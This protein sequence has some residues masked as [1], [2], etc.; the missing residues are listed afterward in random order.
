MTRVAPLP[1]FDLG[2]SL[3]SS[4]SRSCARLY[5]QHFVVQRAGGDIILSTAEIC[6][7]A[8]PSR[9][10]RSRKP[11]R[12]LSRG[13]FAGIIKVNVYLF[14]GEWKYDSW[15]HAASQK[16]LMRPSISGQLLLAFSCGDI[17][18][19][20]VAA[21]AVERMR[22]LQMKSSWLRRAVAFI[23]RHAA[24]QQHPRAGSRRVARARISV[25]ISSSRFLLTV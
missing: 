14:P 6:A 23:K 18:S 25:G 2:I 1:V 17:G 11:S 15:L 3:A 20:A 13:F 24:R 16:L 19:M 10:H 21:A 4:R 9:K 22:A 12:L 8:A 7:R 5:S